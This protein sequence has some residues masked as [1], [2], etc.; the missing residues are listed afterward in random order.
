MLLIHSLIAEILLEHSASFKY[1]TVSHPSLPQ[2]P[3]PA[4]RGHS[5]KEGKEREESR[6]FNMQALTADQALIGN[7]KRSREEALH[8]PTDAHP[9]I[10]VTSLLCLRSLTKSI[11]RHSLTHGLHHLT[12]DSTYLKSTLL[13]LSQVSGVHAFIRGTDFKKNSFKHSKVEKVGGREVRSC[14]GRE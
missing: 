8:H 13:A 2:V 11:R 3:L 12:F 5:Q 14:R 10:E 4:L 1:H 6:S 7:K 9:C